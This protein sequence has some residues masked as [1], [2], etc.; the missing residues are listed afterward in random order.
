MYAYISPNMWVML[1]VSLHVKSVQQNCESSFAV[2]LPTALSVFAY[3]ACNGI[4][5]HSFLPVLCDHKRNTNT[6]KGCHVSAAPSG[7][8]KCIYFVHLQETLNKWFV[9]KNILT[10]NYSEVQSLYFAKNFS[11]ISV[12]IDE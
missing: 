8:E 6:I 1:P 11:I 12:I 9:R 2:V 7:I 5:I 10:F 3:F 4:H